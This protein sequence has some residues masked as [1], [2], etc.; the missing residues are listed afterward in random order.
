MD[1]ELKRND[2]EEQ[3]EKQRNDT[4]GIQ[5]KMQKQVEGKSINKGKLSL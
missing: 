1:K 3:I 2:G 5:K 4:N